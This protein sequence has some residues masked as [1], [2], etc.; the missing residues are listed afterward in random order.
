MFSFSLKETDLDFVVNAAAPGFEDKDKLKRFI[1]EDEAFRK[2]LVGSEKVFQKI[3]QDDSFAVRIS[4]PLFFEILLRRAYHN[5]TKSTYTTEKIGSHEILVFDAERVASFLESEPVLLYLAHMLSSFLK[6]ESLVLAMRL[7]KGIWRKMRFSNMD[8]DA[9][10]MLCQAL[11][12]EE[13]FNLYKRI[14]DIC[15]FIPG[16][17]PEFTYYSHFYPYSGEKRPLL[18]GALSRR[19]LEDFEREGKKYYS[20]A[21]EHRD[22]NLTGMTETFRKLSEDYGLARKALNFLSQKFLYFK[23]RTIFELG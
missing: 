1:V 23:K 5:L 3:M 13:R 20:L 17:F 15:L 8:I 14:A 21:M 18:P 4:P 10:E 7:R 11:E 16:I 19:S 12:E 22:A 9:L 6:I 2:G